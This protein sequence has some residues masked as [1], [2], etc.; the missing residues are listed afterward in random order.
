[1]DESGG[2]RAALGNAAIAA[3]RSSIA[4]SVLKRRSMTADASTTTIKLSVA[5]LALFA[6]DLGRR[7]RR[8]HGRP[9]FQ[10]RDQLLDRG[11]LGVSLDLFEEVIRQGHAC[12]RGTRLQLSM[13]LIRDIAKL[14]HLGHANRMNACGAHVNMCSTWGLRLV[15][16]MRELANGEKL[17]RV[18]NVPE[19]V[20]AL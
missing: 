4:R 8:L 1:G 13:K 11:G 2:G 16:R 12:L 14:D 18:L 19:V 5:F 6:N 17:M 9:A 20:L 7:F 15:G 3:G 10:P